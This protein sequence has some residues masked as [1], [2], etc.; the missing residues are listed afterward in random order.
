[1]SLDITEADWKIWKVLRLRCID[2]FCTQT[3]DQIQQ[4]SR[5]TDPIHD[6]HRELYQLVTDRD[7]EIVQLFDPLTRSRAIMQLI[8]LHRS[9]LVSND[10]ISRFSEP[11]QSICHQ[12][13]AL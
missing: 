5:G 2:Q 10:D 7:R 11:L 8:N 6:R 13:K 1:M 3:F 9:G 4:L 12:T